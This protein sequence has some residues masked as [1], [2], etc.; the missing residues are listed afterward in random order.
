MQ[1]SGKSRNLAETGQ[2]YFRALHTIH[3]ST[4]TQ[5]AHT[6]HFNEGKRDTGHKLGTSNVHNICTIN[7]GSNAIFKW[8]LSQFNIKAS[9]KF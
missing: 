5:C 4:V 6:E 8:S 1:S 9:Y 2:M 3:Y 7:T